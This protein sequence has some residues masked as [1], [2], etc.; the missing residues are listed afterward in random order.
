MS[1]TPSVRRVAITGGPYSGK[2]TL[3]RALGEAGHRTVPE[4]AILE[5]EALEVELGDREAQRSFRRESPLEFQ[6]RVFARQLAQERTAANA[7]GAAPGPL[8]M[9]RSVVDGIAYLE[10]DGVEPPP[11]L[12]RT[13]EDRRPDVA[14]LLDTLTAF[15]G[16]GDTGR[17]SDRARSLRLRDRI[18]RVYRRLGVPVVPLP[19]APTG[20]RMA[21]VLASLGMGPPPPLSGRAGRRPLVV[22]ALAAG[23][24][25]RLY[26]QTRDRAKPLLDVGGRAVLARILDRAL[27][28]D[29]VDGCVVVTNE[30]FHHQF[31]AWA[32]DYDAP[33]P[34]HLLN[35]GAVDNQER[36][37]GLTD[38]LLGFQRAQREAPGADVLVLAGDNLVEEDLDP[39]RATYREL[40]APLILCRRIP[41]GI[42][43]SR[44][45]EVQV[46]AEGRVSRFREKPA[47]PDS[48]L[49]ATCFYFLPGETRAALERYLAAGGDTDAPGHFLAWLVLRETVHAR[50]LRGRSFDIGD[51]ES[52]TRAREAFDRGN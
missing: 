35:D 44:H 4:A 29:G 23:F 50:S 2:T 32:A 7:R 1:T 34:L 47:D 28:I 17:T 10:E 3:V 40:G 21:R 37:G 38:L 11:D 15:E 5:I 48:E 31:E 18:G 49:A 30:R 12:L 14:F 26:P 24:A 45:G 25:T 36:C 33:V 46:D 52:L 6:H 16:R 19:E 20:E 41:G 39:F 27:A 43:P 13:A 42:P 22:V 9:D 8:F 51:A